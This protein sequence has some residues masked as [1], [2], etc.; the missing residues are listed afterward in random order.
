VVSNGIG[1]INNISNKRDTP[2]NRTLDQEAE[3]TLNMYTDPDTN[4][5]EMIVIAVRLQ[6]RLNDSKVR[7][8]SYPDHH[9][10]VW[11]P[12][13]VRAKFKNSKNGFF[14]EFPSPS[15]KNTSLG[16][17]IDFLNIISTRPPNQCRIIAHLETHFVSLNQF[18]KQG[19]EIE[20]FTEFMYDLW[21][22][23]KTCHDPCCSSSNYLANFL[24]QHNVN[25]GAVL[26][27]IRVDDNA[28]LLWIAKRIKDRQTCLDLGVRLNLNPDET[29]TLIKKYDEDELMVATMTIVSRWRDA[30]KTQSESERKKQLTAAL[31]AL[32]QEMEVKSTMYPT[33]PS[34][35]LK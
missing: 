18:M 17:M 23:S 31:T 20:E 26:D 16:A 2:R 33:L 24:M 4:T 3:D 21:V 6:K 13:L 32:L 15:S 30:T 1:A 29:W 5:P 34:R 11:I 19:D 27:S 7:L 9:F 35:F 28:A 8:H 22:H 12:M 25:T 10:G 14:V